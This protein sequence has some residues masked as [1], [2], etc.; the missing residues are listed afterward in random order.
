MPSLVP[1]LGGL[2]LF[3]DG[4]AGRVRTDHMGRDIGMALLPLPLTPA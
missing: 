2:A 1:T 4:I 3:Y